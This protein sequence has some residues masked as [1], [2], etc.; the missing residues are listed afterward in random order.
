M[1]DLS[2]VLDFRRHLRECNDCELRQN[3][4]SPVPWHGDLNPELAVL[5]M[6]PGKQEDEAGRPFI[7]DAGQCLRKALSS[8]GLVPEIVTYSNSVQCLPPRHEVHTS[9]I[10]ACRKWMRGQIA[11]INPEYLIILGAVALESVCGKLPWAKV[12]SL[13][14]RPLFWANPPV[15]AR[16]KLW[17]TYHPSWAMRQPKN[18]DIFLEDLMAFVT[19]RNSGEEWPTSCVLC[20]D[21]LFTWDESGWGVPLCERHERKG[22]DAG[23]L[24]DMQQARRRDEETWVLSRRGRLGGGADPGWDALSAQ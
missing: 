15:P 7:G 8:C 10:N 5:G 16:P 23:L 2:L 9:H 13:H 4:K 24:R 17:I 3:A 21:D 6:S 12:V 19:W 22:M 18:Y 11:F 14:G 1:T 20:Q